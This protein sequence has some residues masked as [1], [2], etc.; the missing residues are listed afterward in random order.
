MSP[1]YPCCCGLRRPNWHL[2]VANVDREEAV[3]Y[4]VTKSGTELTPTEIWSSGNHAV[5]RD[6]V[7][8]PWGGVYLA[9]EPDGDGNCVFRYDMRGN[10]IWAW[11]TP[12]DV[13]Y[14]SR[15]A[16]GPLGEVLVGLGS[17]I[18]GTPWLVMLDE[19]AETLWTW[20]PAVNP[21]SGPT[22][23]AIDSGGNS[24][25]AIS[26]TMN[27]RMLRLDPDG[28]VLWGKDPTDVP[29]AAS[30]ALDLNGDVLVAGV[31]STFGYGLAKYAA[32]DGGLLWAID[33]RTSEGSQV[34]AQGVTVDP[35]NNV[36]CITYSNYQG[37]DLEDKRLAKFDADGNLVWESPLSV[38]GFE[39]GYDRNQNLIFWGGQ[40]NPVWVMDRDGE[41]HTWAPS[42]PADSTGYSAGVDV[43]PGRLGA[44]PP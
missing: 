3:T 35:D 7:T 25:A 32:S 37:A 15:I 31:T 16:V 28:D 8:S 22:G 14:A 9:T 30:L 33:F 36:Y 6:V 39:A 41:L 5:V 19:D 29:G 40:V 44:F 1:G 12:D 26:L 21:L 34:S 38:E 11:P 42:P 43:F 27:P 10:L 18:D 2:V 20:S 23:V 17:T 4:R 13:L 24:V